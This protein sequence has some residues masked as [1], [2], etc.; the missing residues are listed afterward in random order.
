MSFQRTTLAVALA[1]L[2]GSSQAAIVSLSG[3]TTGGPSFNRL[4]EDVSGLSSEG[5]SVR[6]AAYQFTVDAA[7]LY[8][9]LT[10]ANFDN[11]AFLY[12]GSFDA[13][14]PL[15]GALKGNDDL[16]SATTAGFSHALQAGGTYV[17]LTTGF[18][19]GDAGV[20]STTIGGPGLIAAVPEPSTYA[21]LALGLAAVGAVARRQGQ[22][23]R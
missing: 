17:Y 1:L 15:A 11:M 5:T 12:A 9:F 7:G 23:G 3:D 20:F 2:A 6:Y 16:V 14:L 4:L 8:T 10:T 13:T 22:R 19:N 18:A 21:L